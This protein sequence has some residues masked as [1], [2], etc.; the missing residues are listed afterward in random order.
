MTRWTSLV[1]ASLL[2]AALVTPA[3]A[4]TVRIETTVP[5]VDHSEAAFNLA[6]QQAVETTVQGATAMGLSWIWVDGAR[7]LPDSLVVRMVATDDEPDDEDGALDV[8]LETSS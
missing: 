3:W 4:R 6:M 7:V 5:L 2:A 1:A 8:D